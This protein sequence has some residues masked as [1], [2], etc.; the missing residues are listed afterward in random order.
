MV[1]SIVDIDNFSLHFYRKHVPNT[2]QSLKDFTFNL[3]TGL[4]QSM[5][6]PYFQNV[7][8]SET[9]TAWIITGTNN[10]DNNDYED[11]SVADNL[12]SNLAVQLDSDPFTL[13]EQLHHVKWPVYNKAKVFSVNATLKELCLMKNDEFTHEPMLIGNHDLR[14]KNNHCALCLHGRTNCGCVPGVRAFLRGKIIPWILLVLV[15]FVKI[16][17]FIGPTRQVIFF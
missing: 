6:N 5:S 10:Q 11:T 3:G 13:Q 17:I 8:F 15:L 7:L 4:L 1:N 16:R 14:Y 2:C 12:P 9:T